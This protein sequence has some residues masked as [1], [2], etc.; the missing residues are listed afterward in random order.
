MACALVAGY[1]FKNQTVSLMG[2]SLGCQ[3]IKSCLKTLELFGAR[4]II[5]EVTLLGGAVD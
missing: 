5:H 2:F 4:D 3:V 1:M